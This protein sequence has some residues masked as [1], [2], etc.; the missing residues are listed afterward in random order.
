MDNEDG[1]NVSALD[2]VRARSRISMVNPNRPD[3]RV[4]I[5]CADRPAA[6]PAMGQINNVSGSTA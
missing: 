1:K 4:A 5:Y 2:D 6:S 3:R